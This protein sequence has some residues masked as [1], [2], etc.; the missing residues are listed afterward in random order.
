VEGAA[1]FLPP[2]EVVEVMRLDL[3]AG[4]WMVTA[5]AVGSRFRAVSDVVVLVCG[6]EVDGIRKDASIGE[7]GNLWVSL[8]MMTIVSSPAP[9]VVSVGCT[10]DVDGMHIS[11]GDLIA[12]A[13]DSVDA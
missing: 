4:D 3:P 8:T 11:S 10:A 6:I 7:T 9:T 5:K 1:F 13:V 12:V 2:N